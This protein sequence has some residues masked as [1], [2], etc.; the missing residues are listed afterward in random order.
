MKMSAAAFEELRTAVSVLDTE[1]RRAT[2][3]ARD[4]PRADTVRN[5]DQRY[6]WDLLHEALP[7]FAIEQYAA[8]LDDSH[9]DTGL[10]KAVPALG[11]VVL[12]DTSSTTGGSA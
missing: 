6:R 2:Y 3:R 8:G 1:D 5:I 4:F 10:R 11:A 9:I 12:A 7:R